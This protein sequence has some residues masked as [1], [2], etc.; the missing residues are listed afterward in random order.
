MESVRTVQR[1]AAGLI[2]I[3]AAAL[4]L[5]AH[6]ALSA[7]Q[8]AP[9]ERVAALVAQD[10]DGRQWLT[11]KEAAAAAATVEERLRLLM[12]WAE[13]YHVPVT[14][15][16]DR[17][18][19]PSGARLDSSAAR[20]AVSALGAAID[21]AVRRSVA[22]KAWQPIGALTPWEAFLRRHGFR[23]VE[24]RPSRYIVG[25]RHRVY[26]RP[27]RIPQ[28]IHTC[29]LTIRPERSTALFGITF[30]YTYPREVAQRIEVLERRGGDYEGALALSLP[31]FQADR[32]LLVAV[33]EQA[34]GEKWPTYRERWE[35]FIQ[36]VS[37]PAFLPARARVLATKDPPTVSEVRR[38]E[39]LV[40]H[41]YD[42]GPEGR[43]E[44]VLEANALDL[45]GNLLYG[46]RPGL[47]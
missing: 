33:G 7:A 29:L 34:L 20:E 18:H 44:V 12:P 11:V 3:W 24:E 30:R 37:D 46:P 45:R 16:L 27:P 6:P 32:S 26:R 5:G 22:A 39:G 2:A 28:A 1:R 31:S 21:D 10:P 9:G 43:L 40:A 17:L 15:P 35:E 13:R 38:F 25:V 4:V 14:P 23:F 42:I 41:L 19:R 47:R 8:E 36:Y